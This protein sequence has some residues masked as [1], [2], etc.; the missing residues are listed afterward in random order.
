MTCA[1]LNASPRRTHTLPP[2]QTNN[3][4]GGEQELAAEY[5]SAA[6]EAASQFLGKA[7][8]YVAATVDKLKAAGNTEL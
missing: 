4:G 2:T 3:G 6:Q 5:A 1:A 7:Q 8:E